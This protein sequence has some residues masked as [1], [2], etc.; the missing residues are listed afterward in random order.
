MHGPSSIYKPKQPK[1]VLFSNMWVDFDVRGQHWMN[2]FTGGSVIMDYEFCQKWQFK[3][4][5]WIYFLQTCSFSLLKMLT[6]GLEW[7]GLLWCFYQLFGLSFWRHPFTAEHPLESKWWN[8]TFLQI[9][10][11]ETNSLLIYR[12]C[13]KNK[14]NT[15]KTQHRNRMWIYVFLFLIFKFS[16]SCKHSDIVSL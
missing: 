6:D 2:F 4:K 14:K 8:A 12:V 16:L 10:N 5:R 9:Q 3:V 7:C 1:T 15:H 11:K 13:K